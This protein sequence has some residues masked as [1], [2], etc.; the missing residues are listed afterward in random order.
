MFISA[1]VT[2]NLA[3]LYKF[4]ADIAKQL[5]GGY[6]PINDALKLWAVRYRSFAQQRFDLYSKGGGDWQELNEKTIERRRK[7][8]AT[9]RAKLKEIWNAKVSLHAPKDSQ[10]NSAGGQP[11]ILRDAGLLFNAL[12]PAFVGAPGAIQQRIKFGIRVGYG[13]PQRHAVDATSKGMATIADIAS[14]HQK[15]NLPHLPQRQIIVDPPL[16]V[17]EKMALDMQRAIEKMAEDV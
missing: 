7:G 16:P 10:A 14:F 11:S 1:T 3:K 15:G 2:V 17:I 13:G 5:E 9:N 8:T 12:A 4:R 6:G